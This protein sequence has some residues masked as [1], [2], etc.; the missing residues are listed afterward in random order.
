MAPDA[1]HAAAP[2]TWSG[3]WLGAPRLPFVIAVQILSCREHVPGLWHLA[4]TISLSPWQHQT[5]QQEEEAQDCE[6]G[7]RLLWG[8]GTVVS[9]GN[10]G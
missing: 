5:P 6:L 1:P 8:Y 4:S 9:A 2:S 10:R 7:L 3:L